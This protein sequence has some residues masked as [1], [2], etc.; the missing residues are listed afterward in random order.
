ML[1]PAG[2]TRDDVGN[3]MVKEVLDHF[4]GGRIAYFEWLGR[5]QYARQKTHQFKCQGRDTAFIKI[6]K[7]KID[8]AVVT[9]VTTKV[10]KM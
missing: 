9:F 10:L 4:P 7:I 6:Y 3:V 5:D 8:Q 2:L 1:G